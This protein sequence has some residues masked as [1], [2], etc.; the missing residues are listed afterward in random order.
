MLPA[1]ILGL[2]ELAPSLVKYFT[3]SKKTE[4]ITEKVVSI[5][6]TVTGTPDENS[7]L[8]ALKASP[9]LVLKFQESVL[10]HAYD[11]EQIQ[12]DVIKEVNTTI[13]V[14]AAANHW[15][16]YSWRPWIGFN[17]GAYIGSLW[18]LPLFNRT[19]AKL[20]EYIV[21][22]VGGILGVASWF[23]GKMQADPNVP[24]DNRG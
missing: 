17:F 20:D 11:L 3:G 2:I 15:P 19:P 18:I 23:R 21:L 6:K 10:D 5:A 24:T 22:A 16:T 7:A 13:R 1:A 14:E 8:A 4:E 12:A 9:E